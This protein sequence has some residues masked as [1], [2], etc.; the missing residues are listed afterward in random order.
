MAS[1]STCEIMDAYRSMEADG[2]YTWNRQQCYS[3][4]DYLFVSSY[5]ASKI[6]KVLMNSQIM[7]HYMWKYT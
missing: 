2:G 7:L 3:R 6:I 1:N 5:L 4:L